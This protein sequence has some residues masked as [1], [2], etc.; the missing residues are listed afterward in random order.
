LFFLVFAPNKEQIFGVEGW[1]ARQNAVGCGR[2]F[3]QAV[4]KQHQQQHP[5]V[6]YCQVDNQQRYRLQQDYTQQQ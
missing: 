5:N 3:P 4:T 6:V 1:T 2:H